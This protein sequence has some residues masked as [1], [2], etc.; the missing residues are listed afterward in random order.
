VS[1]D[2]GAASLKL[3][4]LSAQRGQRFEPISY[5]MRVGGEVATGVL[6]RQLIK[7][8]YGLRG[9]VPDG[10]LVR[11]SSIGLPET[12]AFAVQDRFISDLLAA[13]GPANL[14]YLI[15]SPQQ[16]VEASS[17]VKTQLIR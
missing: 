11:V 7:L 8:K 3:K 16:T 15:G 17:Q 1:Y 4:R 2:G 5:W 10:T 14:K 6:D 13:M 12:Q 9:I